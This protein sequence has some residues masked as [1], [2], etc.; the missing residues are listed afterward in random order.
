MPEHP[1]LVTDVYE[2]LCPP[3]GHSPS[4]QEI[5]LVVGVRVSIVAADEVVAARVQ[6]SRALSSNTMLFMA[7]AKGTV[8]ALLGRFVTYFIKRATMLTVTRAA[9]QKTPTSNEG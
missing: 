9:T 4:E 5:V 8:S 7:Y 3:P 2:Q 6:L 1:S